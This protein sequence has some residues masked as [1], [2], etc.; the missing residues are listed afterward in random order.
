LLPPSVSAIPRTLALIQVHTLLRILAHA[1]IH[2]HS[3]TRTRTRLV[4]PVRS[5][6]PAIHAMSH[7]AKLRFS[8]HVRLAET[9]VIC[10]AVLLAMRRPPISPKLRTTTD[11]LRG[12]S[13][14]SRLFPQC[15]VHK[16]AK[17]SASHCPLRLLPMV[18]ALP[19]DLMARTCLTIL[20]PRVPYIPGIIV[21]P[22]LVRTVYPILIECP[23]MLDHIH[24]LTTLNFLRTLLR[25]T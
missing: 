5:I 25:V 4:T 10:A 19:T 21:H 7:G 9:G 16:A 12:I 18:L 23:I 2:I 13:S 1:L 24:Q 8:K 3:R 11:M 6:A 15:L 17:V 22:L 14:S 20:M